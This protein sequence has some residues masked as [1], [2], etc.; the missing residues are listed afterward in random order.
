[1]AR[2]RFVR[3]LRCMRW[4]ADNPFGIRPRGEAV[5]RNSAR[6]WRSWRVA[7]NSSHSSVWLAAFSSDQ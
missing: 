6:C 3:S 7:M 4:R 5:S 1:M 2:P